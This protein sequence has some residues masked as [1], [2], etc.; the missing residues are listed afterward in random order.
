MNICIRRWSARTART[1]AAG[2]C[3]NGD[4][5]KAQRFDEYHKHGCNFYGKLV[6]IDYSEDV[7]NDPNWGKFGAEVTFDY[8]AKAKALIQE[9]QYNVVRVLLAIPDYVVEIV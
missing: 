6:V 9:R 5:M 1:R 2:S 4:M 7:R 8:L 3:G